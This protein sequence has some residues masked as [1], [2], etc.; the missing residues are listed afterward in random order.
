[1]LDASGSKDLT[2]E[3]SVLK[4]YD[5]RMLVVSSDRYPCI[6]LNVN[7]P[8]DNQHSVIVTFL[9]LQIQVWV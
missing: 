8:N 6:S 5:A 9:K 7:Q 3:C 1:M 2:A 4:S